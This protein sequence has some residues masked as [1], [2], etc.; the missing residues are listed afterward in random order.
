M[1][2]RVGS[3]SQSLEGSGAPDEATF[4]ETRKL[5]APA[6]ASGIVAAAN[7][8]SDIN[9]LILAVDATGVSQILV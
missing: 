5:S 4:P 3:T 2:E 9:P 8:I 7:P 6:D 1:P